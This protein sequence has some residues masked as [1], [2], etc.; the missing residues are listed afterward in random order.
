MAFLAAQIAIAL[1]HQLHIAF[2][3]R[4]EVA[5]SIERTQVSTVGLNVIFSPTS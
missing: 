1:N 3:V 5:G 4:N 2:R